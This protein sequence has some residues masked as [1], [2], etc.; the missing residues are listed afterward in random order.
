MNNESIVTPNSEEMKRRKKEEKRKIT[1]AREIIGTNYLITII[2]VNTAP[3]LFFKYYLNNNLLLK[4][5]LMYSWYLILP[6]LSAYLIVKLNSNK[7]QNYVTN[8]NYKKI[9]IYSILDL[10][11]LGFFYVGFSSNVL[12]IPIILFYIGS[13][14]YLLCQLDKIVKGKI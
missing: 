3:S 9:K 10:I 1:K 7:L 4:N 13:C 14:V 6:F 5:I 11:V 12:I 2:I 8:A